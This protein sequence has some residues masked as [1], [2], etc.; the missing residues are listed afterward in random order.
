MIAQDML[1]AQ[2]WLAV[3][4]V[5]NVNM[6]LF[7]IL[8]SYSCPEVVTVQKRPRADI[9]PCGSSKLDK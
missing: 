3:N 6:Y 5:R 8:T 4:G 7:G 2:Y 1:A 9:H